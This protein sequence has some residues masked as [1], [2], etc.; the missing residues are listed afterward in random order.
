[1]AVS[2]HTLQYKRINKKMGIH[3][4]KNA[5]T[6]TNIKKMLKDFLMLNSGIHIRTFS[7]N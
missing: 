5:Q 1:M 6:N 3:A 7:E 4:A 2:G